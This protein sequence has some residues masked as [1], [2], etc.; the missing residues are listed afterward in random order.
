MK[1]SLRR[2]SWRFI[3]P[4]MISG[5]TVFALAL[6]SLEKGKIPVLHVDSEYPEQAVMARVPMSLARISKQRR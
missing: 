5:H 6:V 1:V 4:K 3:R 2:R